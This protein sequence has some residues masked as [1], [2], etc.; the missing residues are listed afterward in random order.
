MSNRYLTIGLGFL[1]ATVFTASSCEVTTQKTPIA[2]QPTANER[3]ETPSTTP[4]V[5]PTATAT[6]P[7]KEAQAANMPVTLP[8]LDAMFTDDAFAKELKS[9][10]G[11]TD[12][13]I[14]K[15]RDV[16]RETTTNLDESKSDASSTTDAATRA[17]EQIQAILGADKTN[18][19]AELVRER[20]EKGTDEAG[21][22]TTTQTATASTQ[23]PN[24]IPTDTR[25]VVNAPAYRM[26]VFKDGTLVRSYKIG[27]GYPEFPLP[28][29]MRDAKTII[30]NPTWTP[31]DEP[32]VRGKIKAGQKVEAGSALN[33]LGPIKIPIGLPSLIHGGKSPVRLGGFASHGCVGLTN[34][35]VQDFAF[36]LASV[37]ETNLSDSDISEYEKNK[38]VT[39]NV[40]LGK[41]VP[42]ELRYDTI[43]VENGNLYIYRDVYERGTNTEDSLR[44]V[45]DGY[46]VSFDSL[47][48]T[49]KTKILAG[50]KQMALD[51]SGK[52]ADGNPKAKT[53]AKKGD[54]KEKA[55]TVTRNISGKKLFVIELAA[56]KGKGYPAPVNLN[57]GTQA[58]KPFKINDKNSNQTNVNSNSISNVNNS[59]V[60]KPAKK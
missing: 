43:T 31:P 35:E 32:W 53:N 30:F 44:K 6:P 39:K 15:L 50:L 23:N 5:V 46:G 60:S 14:Q 34:P 25:I 9:K 11:L 33:P 37:T 12:E 19:L 28:T 8:V 41:T 52:T 57:T 20:W 3:I 42:V 49:E 7:S 45:L 4:N 17:N 38:T 54:E 1:L 59:N 10:L 36:T 48:E 21:N 40:K 56:L 24:G 58:R 22:T 47:T 18:Q 29:G 26:D 16:S 13:Q 27:I 51:P 2:T 55:P